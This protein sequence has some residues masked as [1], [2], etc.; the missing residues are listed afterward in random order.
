MRLRLKRKHKKSQ[1]TNR[2][3]CRVSAS[4][5]QRR[6]LCV[7]GGWPDRP[8]GHRSRGRGRFTTHRADADADRGPPCGGGVDTRWTASSSGASRA[9]PGRES[10]RSAARALPLGLVLMGPTRTA[11]E[12]APA[13]RGGTCRVAGS[14]GVE[15][16]Q[17]GDAHALELL[18]LAEDED[19]LMP[20]LPSTPH[21]DRRFC[22]CQALRDPRRPCPVG[23]RAGRRQ[24]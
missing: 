19:S 3:G 23:T 20:A 16:D 6:A 15:H 1:K 9:R 8:R 12:A 4:P 14:G 2:R 18:H 11:V 22:G 7:G 24:G 21:R 10:C 5:D 13:P 17:V